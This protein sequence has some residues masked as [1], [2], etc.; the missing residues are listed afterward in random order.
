[1]YNKVDIGCM[2]SLEIACHTIIKDYEKSFICLRWRKIMKKAM[3]ITALV[4][5]IAIVTVLLLGVGYVVYVYAQYY[6]HGDNID[7][8]SDKSIELKANASNEFTAMTYNIGFGAYDTEFSFFMDQ[9]VDAATGEI[10]TGKYGKAVSK[11]NV[12]K[13]T[14]GSIGLVEA[15]PTDFLFMQEVDTKGTRSYNVNQYDTIRNS[16]TLKNYNHSFAEN[17]HSAFLAYPLNDFIGANNSG[18]ATFSKY[19]VSSNTRRSYPLDDGFAKFFDLDRC[20]MISR[21]PL[22]NGKELTL[23]NNHMSAYDEGGTIRAQQLVMLKTI[24][25]EERANGNYVIVGGDFNHDLNQAKF[26][27]GQERPD[28]IS[29]LLP[30]DLGEGFAIA[31]DTSI[32]TCRAAERPYTKGYNYEVV[33]DGFI[34]SDN[35]DVVKVQNIDAGYLFSDHNPVKITFKLK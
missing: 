22:D 25:E 28:W 30:S 15:N 23:I 1:M 33:V 12:L 19:N 27:T 16:E 14:N 21:V 7:I 35:I 5:L 6:R 20:I 32:G 2:M 10:Q 4:T 26:P 3:K 8:L 31:S 24:M 18:L 29:D 34:V 9:G 13:N 11:E 17:Y